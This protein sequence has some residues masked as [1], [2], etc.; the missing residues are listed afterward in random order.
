[1][2]AEVI[3]VIN[4]YELLEEMNN[5]V[6][7]TNQE[8]ILPPKHKAFNPVEEDVICRNTLKDIRNNHLKL[9]PN[10]T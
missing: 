9:E 3:H 4:P 2:P 7:Q 6:I 8:E 5:L 10:E 1:M